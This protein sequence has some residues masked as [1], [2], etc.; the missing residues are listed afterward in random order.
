MFRFEGGKPG[1]ERGFIHKT[2]LGG[3]GKIAGVLSP[4]VPGAGVV[5]GIATKLAGSKQQRQHGKLTKFPGENGVLR[6]LA[7]AGGNG[8]RLPSGCPRGYRP[9]FRTGECEPAAGQGMGGM[10]MHGAGSLPMIVT[11]DRAVC[12]K[13]QVLGDDGFCYHKTQISNKQRMWPQGR[14]PLLTGGDMRAIGVAS[15]AAGKLERTTKRLQRM[16][17]MKKPGSRRSPPARH[18]HHPAA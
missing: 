16:G 7:P 4:I 14:R 17:M 18:H 6:P 5:S 13:K 2:I 8:T 15:R 11:F 10:G 1:D 12:G 3:I 9:D